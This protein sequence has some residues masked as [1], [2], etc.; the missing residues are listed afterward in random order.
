[1]QIVR[2]VRKTEIE[3]QIIS[4]SRDAERNADSQEIVRMKEREMQIIS[5]SKKDTE[6]NANGQ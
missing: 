4:Q 2:K 6:R 5:Q 3:M 1:M